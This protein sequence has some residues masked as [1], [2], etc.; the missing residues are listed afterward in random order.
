MGEAFHPLQ[1]PAYDAV[2]VN[3]IEKIVRISTGL[4]LCARETF[5]HPQPYTDRLHAL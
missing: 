3:G 4:V 1:V 5:T 2:R